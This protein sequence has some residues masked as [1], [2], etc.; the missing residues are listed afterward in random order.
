MRWEDDPDTDSYKYFISITGF[1]E[2][3]VS[4]KEFIQ[5]ER[6]CGFYS[7]I[8]GQPATSGFGK[9]KDGISISGRIVE[10]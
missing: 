6:N 4:K 5:Y 2:K 8:N 10:N 3:E 1:G 9:F 7:K